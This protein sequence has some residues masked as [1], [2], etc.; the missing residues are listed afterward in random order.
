MRPSVRLRV[1]ML[2]DLDAQLAGRI[3]VRG[4]CDAA[5]E[6]GERDGAA[7]AR[8][9]DLLDDLGNG[10]DL[11]VL[12][13]VDRDEQDALL[14]A[15]VDGERDG[16]VGEDNDVFERNQEQSCHRVHL[17]VVRCTQLYQ[18][19]LLSRRLFAAV[20]ECS[21][22]AHNQVGDSFSGRGSHALKQALFFNCPR[23][24]GGSAAC[25]FSRRADSHC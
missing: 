3:G 9:A 2:L 6:A 16:H 21:G 24:I 14:V 4:A 10:A 7:A 23:E 17:T 12:A 1:G 8:Q 19:K 25:W 13:L 5:V 20:S 15:D 18:L 11:G 22:R